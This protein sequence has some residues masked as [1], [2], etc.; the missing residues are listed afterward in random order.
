[1]R[2][3]QESSLEFYDAEHLR[4]ESSIVFLN[5]RV[6]KLHPLRTNSPNYR[7][8][9][10]PH[11]CTIHSSDPNAIYKI[12][13]VE[14]VPIYPL[15]IKR[16]S[17]NMIHPRSTLKT[18]QTAQIY[19]G[20]IS[21]IF[22]R[23]TQLHIHNTVPNPNNNRSIPSHHPLISFSPPRSPGGVR[24]GGSER[25]GKVRVESADFPLYETSGPIRTT[26]FCQ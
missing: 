7:N 16:N 3:I 9:L 5:T 10:L 22:I 4:S 24:K 11:M 23:I 8:A 14:S 12:R 26:G 25:Q 20:P 19:D 1:M 18:N 13:F 15:N 6:H 2:E 21:D 17:S